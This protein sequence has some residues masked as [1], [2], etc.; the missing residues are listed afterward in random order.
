MAVETGSFRDPSGQ[1]F[2]HDKKIYRC[3]YQPGL[4]DYHLASEKSIYDD[5]IQKKNDD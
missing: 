5:L 3:I 2:I 1:V 4:K